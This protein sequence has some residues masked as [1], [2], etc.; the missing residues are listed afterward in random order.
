MAQALGTSI[1]SILV[2]N[3]IQILL[4]YY[5]DGIESY[6]VTDRLSRLIQ[7]DHLEIEINSF[8][9]GCHMEHNRPKYLIVKFET[10]EGVFYTFAKEQECMIITNKTKVSIIYLMYQLCRNLER[11]MNVRG[12]QH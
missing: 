8:I 1:D 11:E 4:A 3:E 5:G 9:L 6:N 7:K 12:Q 10:E 2:Q